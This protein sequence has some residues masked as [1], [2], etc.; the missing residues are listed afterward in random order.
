MFGELCM[1]IRSCISTIIR[2][3]WVIFFLPATPYVACVKL[4]LVNGCADSVVHLLEEI[5]KQIN[6]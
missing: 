1:Y 3:S 2:N 5:Y 6:E 4:T